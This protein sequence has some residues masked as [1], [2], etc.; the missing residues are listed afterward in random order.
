MASDLTG[1]SLNDAL[2]E[3]YRRVGS[4]LNVTFDFVKETSGGIVDKINATVLVGDDVYQLAIG[5]PA[6]SIGKMVGSKLPANRDDMP[7]IDLDTKYWYE[8]ANASLRVCDHVF[9]TYGDISIR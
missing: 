9:Y 2:Y 4:Q 5:Q 1:D 3:R 6:T 7:Y 8:S